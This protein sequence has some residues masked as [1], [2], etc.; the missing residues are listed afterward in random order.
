VAPFEDITRHGEM[1]PDIEVLATPLPLDAI[2]VV[3]SDPRW[4]T[5]FAELAGRIRRALG[6][7]VLDLEHIGS[8]S[9]PDL[10]AKPVI[11]ICLSVEDS[12]DEAAYVPAL[13]NAGFKLSLR[14]PSW[15]QHRCLVTWSPPTVLHV[16]GRGSPGAIRHLMFRDW[17]RE[18]PDD[19]RRYAEAKR[20][21]AEATSTLGEDGFAYNE[22]KQP[23]IR[24]I[25]NRMFRSHGMV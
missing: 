21:A 10:P 11:D 9:V 5:Q 2:A 16:W 19:R 18:H 25:M 17:L 1:A 12:T 20:A 6:D 7:R 3:D 23:V 13:E 15:H 14:E 4:A 8:T 24:D 22:R